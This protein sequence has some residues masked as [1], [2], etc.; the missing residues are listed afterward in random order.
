MNSTVIL[1]RFQFVGDS[2]VVGCFLVTVLV[3]GTVF[4]TSGNMLILISV[5]KIIKMR[6]LEYIFIANL[7]VSDM[8][9]TLVADPMNIVGK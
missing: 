1:G 5:C 7:A 8:F 9:V 4:G 2:P 6:S 3:L